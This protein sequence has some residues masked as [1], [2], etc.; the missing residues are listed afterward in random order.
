MITALLA[1]W[2]FVLWHVGR[3]LYQILD[4]IATPILLHQ[5]AR[6][7]QGIVTP[8]L[9]HQRAR[10]PQM[11]GLLGRFTARSGPIKAQKVPVP[12]ISLHF[13]SRIPRIT[14]RLCL[15]LLVLC[16]RGLSSVAYHFANRPQLCAVHRRHQRLRLA[17]RPYH[18]GVFVVG[19]KSL[20]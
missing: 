17:V 12:A 14:I 18:L 20:T 1:C 7:L 15:T 9:L 11:S 2:P 10:A 16:R 4:Q 3:I 19:A 13:R 8:V 6:A 5:R